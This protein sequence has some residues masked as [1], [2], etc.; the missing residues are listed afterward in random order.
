V[1]ILRTCALLWFCGV[2]ATT[3]WAKVIRIPRQPDYHSGKIAFSYAGSIWMANEDGT[4]PRRLTVNAARDAFPRSFLDEVTRIVNELGPPPPPTLATP[5]VGTHDQMM[6]LSNLGTGH[7]SGNELKVPAKTLDSAGMERSGYAAASRELFK[8]RANERRVQTMKS[9]FFEKLRNRTKAKGDDGSSSND[10][11]AKLE[12]EFKM[13]REQMLEIQ[14][15]NNGDLHERDSA[16][17][18]LKSENQ[19]YAR[20]VKYVR[21]RL[22]QLLEQLASLD[23]AAADGMS[24][25]AATNGGRSNL[26]RDC[27]AVV[28]RVLTLVA[29]VRRGT[30]NRR[31][32]ERKPKV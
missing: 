14:T 11:L 3:L 24:A 29:R 5:K 17:A 22:G 16:I 32:S 30:L 18:S 26:E 21:S 8:N 23:L 10:E 1:R 13:Y 7:E 12:E 15:K 31:D 19:Q 2:T 27:D 9:G 6:A 25:P 28:E 20:Q 4:N